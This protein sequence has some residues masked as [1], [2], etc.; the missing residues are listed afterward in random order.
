[1]QLQTAHF[2]Q[3]N[4][5][6]GVQL[7]KRCHGEES[8]PS[9]EL[10]QVE[11]LFDRGRSFS[12][13][14][15]VAFALPAAQKV[16]IEADRLYRNVFSRFVSHLCDHLLV[17]IVRSLGLNLEI[18][19]PFR[20]LLEQCNLLLIDWNHAEI[21]DEQSDPKSKV[22]ERVDEA[23]SD[24]LQSIEQ[25]SDV[26]KQVEEAVGLPL[27]QY[28]VLAEVYVPGGVLV[29]IL[30]SFLVL[31]RP[32]IQ[33]AWG[34]IEKDRSVEL[35]L[36]LLAPLNVGCCVGKHVML[37]VEWNKVWAEAINLNCFNP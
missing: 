28:L 34:G 12:H 24:E 26:A 22:R 5:L 33:S 3:D 27:N 25:T 15:V 6:A 16:T 2:L 1:M 4:L 21:L 11:L 30:L 32:L 36:I 9:N 14:L 37:K 35:A 18:R 7:R 20:L 23:A 29:A 17:S 19:P 13:H 31:G 10:D 8:L